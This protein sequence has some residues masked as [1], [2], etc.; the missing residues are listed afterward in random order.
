[1][2]MLCPVRYFIVMTLS[3]QGGAPY[4]CCVA[5]RDRLQGGITY[6]QPQGLVT[7][8]LRMG[9]SFHLLRSKRSAKMT[10]AFLFPTQAPH[11]LKTFAG[12]RPEAEALLLT[13]QGSFLR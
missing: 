11:C 5:H 3:E 12:P 10:S 13:W 8:S 7:L 6:E 9:A 4:L 2:L 1:M